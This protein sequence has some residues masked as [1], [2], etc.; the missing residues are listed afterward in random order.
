M[1][2]SAVRPGDPSSTTSSATPSPPPP[3]LPPSRPRTPS[4][5]STKFSRFARSDTTRDAT[6]PRRSGLSYA[7][8]H[9]VTE[10]ARTPSPLSL[11]LP[12]HSHSPAAA[13]TT[14]T[15]PSPSPVQGP[16][17]R[18]QAFPEVPLQGLYPRW[19]LSALQL[20]NSTTHFQTN[21]LIDHTTLSV[22]APG[23]HFLLSVLYV[24]AP[25]VHPPAPRLALPCHRFRPRTPPRPPVHPPPRPPPPRLTPRASPV[26]AASYAIHI[27]RTSIVGR[28]PLPHHSP[29][30][31]LPVACTTTSWRPA[32]CT[33]PSCYPPPLPPL[34]PGQYHS[35]NPRH[36]KTPL[37]SGNIWKYW[38]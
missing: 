11:S 1:Q 23:P 2:S 26:S 19:P 30:F 10:F 33:I 12:S 32:Q 14:M 9:S 37:V 13:T 17:P 4:R 31:T 22:S 28:R 21:T 5:A 27:P 34:S 35:T 16:R 3:P 36:L 18:V 25:R 20:Y 7:L 6:S 29:L 24:G 15:Y 8:T 38:K